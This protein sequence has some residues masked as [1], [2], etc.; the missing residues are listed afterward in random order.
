M[1]DA[2]IGAGLPV[3]QADG[4]IEDYAHYSRGEAPEVALGVQEATGNPP[5]SFRDFANAYAEAFSAAAAEKTVPAAGS[6]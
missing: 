1:W 2:L 5:R 3:W 4:L 6:H